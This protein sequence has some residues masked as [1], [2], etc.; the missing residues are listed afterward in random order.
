ALLS[1]GIPLSS[2]PDLYLH[3]F[4]TRRSS[5]LCGRWPWTPGNSWGNPSLNPDFLDMLSAF[6]EERVEF[7]VVDAYALAVHG[8][9]RAT[10]DMD[11]WVRPPPGRAARCRASAGPTG[12]CRR[13][14]SSRSAYRRAASTWRGDGLEIPV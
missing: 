7:L 4:P 5:D 11:L 14:R 1:T 3:S 13:G 9:P 10:G 2:C 12:P 8:L 6:S